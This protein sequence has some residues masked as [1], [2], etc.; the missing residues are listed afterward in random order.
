MEVVVQCPSCNA[1][2]PV[3]ASEKP[4]EIQCG[5]SRK[6]IALTITS[7]VATDTSV[8]TC[9]MCTGQDF[10]IRKDFDPK[11]G[12]TI[13][14]LGATV[15]AVFYYFGRDLTAY[16]VLAVAVLVDLAVYRRLGDVTICYRCHAVFRC[17]FE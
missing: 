17:C 15:S 13:V 8:D 11:V 16:G 5:S 4:N 6:I 10:Y 2:L 3:K 14:I 7:S 12:L 9:P 1:A